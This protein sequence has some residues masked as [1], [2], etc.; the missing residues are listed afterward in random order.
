[1]LENPRRMSSVKD[2]M[3][4]LLCFSR[5]LLLDFFETGSSSPGRIAVA[6]NIILYH[7]RTD[8]I[9]EVLESSA[10]DR[11]SK[12]SLEADEKA[13]RGNSLKSIF[14]F[15]RATRRLESRSSSVK[16]PM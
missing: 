2:S 10:L 7:Q 12:S 8:Y 14:K 1:M 16:P 3:L 9:S 6:I 15:V 11:I 4:Q 5:F 13:S